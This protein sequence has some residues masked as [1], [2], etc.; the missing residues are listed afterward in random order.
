MLKLNWKTDQLI[1]T[2]LSLIN[3]LLF[4]KKGIE[5]ILFFFLFGYN[6]SH[7][8]NCV[9]SKSGDSSGFNYGSSV[10]ADSNG[11]V[12][13]IGTFQGP[14]I[15]FGSYTLINYGTGNVFLVKYDANGNVLWAKSGQG[16]GN[17]PAYSV[18]VDKDQNV[19]TTGSFQGSSISFGAFTFTNTG[20]HD[21]YLVKYDPNGNVLWAK[22]EGAESVDASYSVATDQI[23]NVYITGY[24]TSSV[25]TIGSYTFSNSPSLFY[26]AKY[27][28]NG[29]VLWAQ[30]SNGIAGGFAVATT[31]TDDV[32]IT[33]AFSSTT[34][35]I[36]TQTLSGQGS[37][38][39]IAKLNSNGNVLWAKNAYGGYGYSLA[40][41]VNG[42]VFVTGSY[43]SATFNIGS[44][45]LTNKGNS[46]MFLAK[47]DSNGNVAWAKSGGSAGNDYGYSVA[48]DVSGIYITGRFTDSIVFNTTTLTATSGTLDPMY[49]AGFD[50]NGNL[51]YA[52]SF[53]SG[54]G[55][56][57]N[58]N[59]ICTDNAKNVYITSDF[60]QNQFSVGCNTLS[61]TGN[62][63]VF[64]AKYNFPDV[65]IQEQKK[66]RFLST[67]YPNPN[68]GNYVLKV[69]NSN[70]QTIELSIFDIAG[71]LIL[72]ENKLVEQ[73]EIQ[74]KNDLSNGTYLLKIK[75]EDG[76]VDIHRLIINK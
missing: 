27:D 55:G 11:N 2:V 74:L 44:Y 25:L 72:K 41:N 36:G 60:Q 20:S 32:F 26:L 9:W 50:F 30:S 42:D 8:Q 35:A 49:F 59:W 53:A 6:F 69:N 46:E 5:K 12:Y 14:T 37:D 56:G 65:G 16:N 10:C 19:Y 29:N 39:F 70:Q 67:L 43:L 13:V 7:S 62:Q 76:S 22:K 21:I 61:L 63:N 3:R 40:T 15:T 57:N 73:T 38:F 28:T 64:V 52:T 71:K 51:L 18:T 33:G 68:D 75:L 66:D 34:M 31:A 45:T 17:D 23:G 58:Q 1:S 4:S 54:G 47:Y 24:S 48:S